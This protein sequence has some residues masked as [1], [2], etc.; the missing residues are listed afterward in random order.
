MAGCPN[1]YQ[2]EVASSIMEKCEAN[3]PSQLYRARDS[4]LG[5]LVSEV[6]GTMC[7]IC[8][9][10]QNTAWMFGIQSCLSLQQGQLCLEMPPPFHTEITLM[11]NDCQLFR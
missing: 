3:L 11:V 1:P 2:S 5:S 6:W 8:E 7:G 9:E 4:S 10:P